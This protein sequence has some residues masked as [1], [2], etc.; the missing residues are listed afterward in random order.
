[1]IDSH[2]LEGTKKSKFLSLSLLA[3][4]FLLA[5][6][7]ATHAVIISASGDIA[8]GS[9]PAS[10]ALGGVKSDT[11]IFG[12]VEKQNYFLGESLFVN[13][14]GSGLFM[15]TGLAAT[16]FIGAGTSI[17]SYFFHSDS[18]ITSGA[19]FI[20][21]ITFSSDILGIIFERQEHNL[22]DAIIGN[23]GTIYP[24]AAVNSD[25]R[26]FEAG[27]VCGGGLVFDCATVSVDLRSINLDLSNTAFIDQVRVITRATVPEPHTLVLLVIGL[28][29]LGIIRR[30][31][32]FK[33]VLTG[34]AIAPL[35]NP[36]D[37]FGAK[38]VPTDN[39]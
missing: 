38:T 20:A 34:T 33:A 39:R 30:G 32:T 1:M 36:G 9:A 25:F 14:T 28:F 6:V 3:V 31:H 26:E 24:T 21:D 16:S 13:G 8:I 23:A 37:R 22:A 10:I 19:N 18:E 15:G 5:P 7:G 12:F 35:R 2:I 4:F 11:Q 17:D 29:G 27:T